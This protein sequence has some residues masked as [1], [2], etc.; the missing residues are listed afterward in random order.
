MAISSIRIAV[1]YQAA[2]AA[3]RW[4]G[5]RPFDGRPGASRLFGGRCR[6]MAPASHLC[7][8]QSTTIPF[9]RITAQAPAEQDF[10][11]VVSKISEMSV[12]VLLPYPAY[13]RFRVVLESRNP[14]GH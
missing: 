3:A 4:R 2:A 12:C 6:A 14:S 9:S 8:P 5:A 10:I 1:S 7:Y 13:V 11:S